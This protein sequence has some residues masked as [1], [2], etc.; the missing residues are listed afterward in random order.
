MHVHETEI[1][2]ETISG[3]HYT[4]EEKNWFKSLPQRILNDEESGSGGCHPD[5]NLKNYLVDDVYDAVRNPDGTY[6]HA[7]GGIYR[8]PSPMM[9]QGKRTETFIAISFPIT[10][11]VLMKKAQLRPLLPKA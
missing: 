3:L 6:G 2:P 8:H 9:K 5:Q 1:D 7:G 10:A 4:P 11:M